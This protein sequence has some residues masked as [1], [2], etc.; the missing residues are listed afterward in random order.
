M[1]LNFVV[2]AMIGHVACGG[3]PPAPPQQTATSA[4]TGRSASEP[5]SWSESTFDAKV[6][7]EIQR[8]F[9]HATIT[10]AGDDLYRIAQAAP[11]S[12]VEVSVAKSRR[13]CRDDWASCQRAVEWTLKA[14]NEASRHAPITSAQLRIVLRTNDK[15][16]ATSARGHAVL[17]RPFSSD[18]QWLLAA[19]L[20]TTIRLDVTP[21]ELGMTGEQAW[22]TAVDNMKRPPAQL[23]TAASEG[24]IVFQDVYA[25]SALLDPDALLQA[26]R[27]AFPRQSGTLLAACPEETVV[28]YTL[29]GR[30]EVTALRSAISA[31][32]LR[33][34]SPLSADV[35]EWTDGAWR[36]VPP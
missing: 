21:E 19:D 2:I 5:A 35:M 11:P 17:A 18:A 16:A 31:V 34:T 1:R 6:L 30:D 12:T 9:P 36:V 8:Q 24:F 25:P 32:G 4:T 26:V 22:R 33:S 28:L 15:V 7:A 20:P 27:T 23:V 10:R 29:G 13:S 14:V 3:A